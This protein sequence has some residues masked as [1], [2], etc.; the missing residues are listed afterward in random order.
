MPQLRQPLCLRLGRRRQGSLPGLQGKDRDHPGYEQ[1]E[2]L[3]AEF[4]ANIES[5]KGII[6]RK[7]KRDTPQRICALKNAYF[8]GV[9]LFR[10]IAVGNRH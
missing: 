2:V 10:F 4:Q 6:N 8:C 1:W 5:E 7:I 9:S 3:K